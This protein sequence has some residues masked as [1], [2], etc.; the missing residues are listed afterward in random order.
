MTTQ[1]KLKKQ[2]AGKIAWN[3]IENELNG[4]KIYDIEDND[5]AIKI[6]SNLRKIEDILI[7]KLSYNEI[8]IIYKTT[9]QSYK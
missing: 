3:I 8:S 1:T 2:L 6:R 9:Y 4:I 5:Q 7:K